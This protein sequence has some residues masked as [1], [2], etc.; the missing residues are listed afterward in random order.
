MP[1]PFAT[2]NIQPQ[3]SDASCSPVVV[4]WAAETGCRRARGGRTAAVRES[5]GA[6]WPPRGDHSINVF[7]DSGNGRGQA[8]HRQS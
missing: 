3:L 6:A 5:R 4:V 7:L 2:P 1:A 8:G